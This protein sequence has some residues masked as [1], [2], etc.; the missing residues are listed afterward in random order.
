MQ[1]ASRVALVTGA[2]SGIGRAIGE[3]LALVEGATV[4][5]IDRDDAGARAAVAYITAQGSRAR[6]FIV[7]LA[8]AQAVQSILA[9]FDRQLGSPDIVINNAGVAAANEYRIATGS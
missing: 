3:Q 9:E 1:H 2:A 5:V 7:D 4:G 8:D 6:V